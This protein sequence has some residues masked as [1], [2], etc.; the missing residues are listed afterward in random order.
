[1]IV[2]VGP[3]RMMEMAPDHEV[4]V[5]AVRHLLVPA[6]GPMDMPGLVGPTLM[7]GGAGCGISATTR[8]AVLVHVTVV[9]V[10]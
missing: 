7:C 3:V 6:G 9:N 8:D 1:M 2:A 5:V 10:V 4:G